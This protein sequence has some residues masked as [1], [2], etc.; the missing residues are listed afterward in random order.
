MNGTRLSTMASVLV[1]LTTPTAFAVVSNPA[2]E[3][4]SRAAAT[5]ESMQSW[6]I[7]A[8]NFTIGRVQSATPVR[9]SFGV[10]GEVVTVDP[11]NQSAKSRFGQLPLS[12][13]KAFGGE[14]QLAAWIRSAQASQR[15]KTAFM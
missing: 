6:H 8:P 7:P 13:V 3:R 4:V 5:Q 10:L 14:G 9:E 12:L 1:T 2:E 11:V 15:G